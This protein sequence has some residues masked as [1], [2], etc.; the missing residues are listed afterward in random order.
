MRR[1]GA[2]LLEAQGVDDV[3]WLRYGDRGRTTE[4]L[5]VVRLAGSGPLPSGVH[6]AHAG[7]TDWSLVLSTDLAPDA[8]PLPAGN[9]TA[10][11]I[12]QLDAPGARVI[13]RLATEAG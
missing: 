10:A 4:Y 7:T 9:H 1:R 5:V 6:A 3:V 8:P 12:L 11:A 2:T 13:A